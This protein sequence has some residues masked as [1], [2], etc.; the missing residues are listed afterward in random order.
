MQATE[1]A[2]RKR[3]LSQ[4][5][6][7]VSPMTAHPK[8]TFR[9]RHRPAPKPRP[10]QPKLILFNKPYGVLT[11][12]SGEPGD[13]TLKD[14]IEIPDVYPAGRLDKDSEGLLLLTN[15]GQLQ[16]RISSPKFKLPKT[17]L[18]LVEGEPSEAALQQLTQGVALRDGVTRPAS[19]S[20]A[21]PPPWLWPRTPP[22]RERKSI[23]DTWLWLTIHEGKNRQV[24]RM[25]AAVGHPTLRLVRYQIGSWTI[26]DLAP[27]TMS[28]VAPSL[29]PGMARKFKK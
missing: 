23:M 7:Q 27:G 25:T 4:L 9:G 26:T 3:I 24:R 14:Y 10:A 17:Y 29:E 1:F 13:R 18:V 6:T 5:K 8:H 20:L 15:D 21:E 19:V 2:G 12:F 28:E 11:Q 22:V 16:A